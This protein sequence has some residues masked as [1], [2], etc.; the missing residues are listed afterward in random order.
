MKIDITIHNKLLN[1]VTLHLEN[2]E[3][4]LQV[5]EH[6]VGM[7]IR[8]KCDDKHLKEMAK[9]FEE[10]ARAIRRHLRSLQAATRF[11]RRYQNG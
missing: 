2:E 11:E 7:Q 3:T 6:T 4:S 1:I 5:D 9:S 8:F 10:N